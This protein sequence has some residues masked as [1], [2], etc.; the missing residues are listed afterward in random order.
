M[1]GNVEVFPLVRGIQSNGY[2]GVNIYLDEIGML[3]RM[4]LNL[5]A[6]EFAG[7]AGF[8]PPP[9]FYGN[10]FLGRVKTFPMLQNISMKIGIDTSLSSA[11]W[12]QKATM[13]NLEHQMKMNELTGRSDLQ[14][15]GAGEDGID[16]VEKEGYSWNQTEDEIEVKLRL[17]SKTTTKD[18]KV[19]FQ[20]KS[21]LVCVRGQDDVGINI[22]LYMKTFADEST[23]TLDTLKS[24][25][26]LI[27]TMLKTDS[28][29]WPRITF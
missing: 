2:N 27:I 4:P 28:I 11:P 9:K 13:E 16:K 14:P 23:W 3:K 25:K 8:N 6:G 19:T 17:H 12:L 5:R 7:K 10:V 15:S 21:V 22:K 26:M 18:I 29:S 1:E 24:D 20:T